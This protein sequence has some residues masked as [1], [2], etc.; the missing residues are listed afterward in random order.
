MKL[1]VWPLEHSQAASAQ[2]DLAA[3]ATDIRII[4]VFIWVKSCV[5]G[6]PRP[7]FPSPHNSPGSGLA[8]DQAGP[9]GLR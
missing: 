2:P 9:T 6:Q 3:A 8:Q 5:Q 4:I 1:Y 7:D